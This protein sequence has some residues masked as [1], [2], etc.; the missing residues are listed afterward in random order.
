ML[1][2]VYHMTLEIFKIAFFGVDT[3]RF[4]LLLDNFIMEGIT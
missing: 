4:S 2:S 1:D 3:S